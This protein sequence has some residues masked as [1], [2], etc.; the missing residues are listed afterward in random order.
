MH[1]EFR[2]LAAARKI[3]GG[4]RPAI[5]IMEDRA[6][7]ERW[8][9]RF[10]SGEIEAGAHIVKGEH[11]TVIHPVA[12]DGAAQRA[13]M[14]VLYI[15]G[16][17]MVYYNSAIFTPLLQFWANTLGTPIEAFDYQKAPEHTLEESISGLMQCIDAQLD[18]DGRPTVLAGDSVGALLALY[19][20]T[21]HRPG[22]FA[23]LLLI[24]P[25]LELQS[26]HPSY[27]EYGEGYFLDA[28]AMRRFREFL[29]PYFQTH[30][31]DPFKLSAEER[32]ALP[33]CTL[34]TSGCDVLRD[35]GLSWKVAME[36]SDVAV[37][38]YH[39]D[40]L[41]HDFCLYTG[42]LDVART[43]VKRILST[44]NATETNEVEMNG[45]V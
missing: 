26:E 10:A 32:C 34:V 17:G 39:F 7:A 6:N 25:V 30:G 45:G 16:G 19:I 18:D 22:R 33:P 38:H 43:A 37:R 42:K 8:I 3:I 21:R 2:A 23:K 9:R 5:S 24:Y 20:A 4:G 1:P 13:N 29:L 11:A 31:F 35:E 14:R 44:L 41:P 28:S 12:A 36:K 27:A 40:D 15:H